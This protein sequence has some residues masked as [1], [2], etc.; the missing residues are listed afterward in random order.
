VTFPRYTGIDD[1]GVA[2]RMVRVEEAF[3]S[4]RGT[5]MLRAREAPTVESRRGAMGRA[6]GD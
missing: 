6:V 4:P 2:G 3:V 5:A 1:G